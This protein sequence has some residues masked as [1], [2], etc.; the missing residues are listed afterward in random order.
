[1]KKYTA[2]A[3]LLMTVAPTLGYAQMSGD[4]TLSY[5]VADSSD[6]EDSI[7]ATYLGFSTDATLGS[8]V[9]AGLD[10]SFLRASTSVAGAD[11]DLDLVG[12]GVDLAYKLNSGLSFGAYVQRNELDVSVDALGLFGDIAATSTG[13]FVG[14]STDAVDVSAFAGQTKTD[15]EFVDTDITDFGVAVRY[16]P[17]DAS[18]V[19][20]NFIST[21]AESGGVDDTLSSVGLAGGVQLSDQWSLF[22]GLNV[23]DVDDTSLDL[24]NFGVGIGYTMQYAGATM[25][26]EI[27]RATL[28]DGAVDADLDRVQLGVSFPF[29]AKRG[30]SIPKSTVAGGVLT[31]SYSAASEGVR[32]SF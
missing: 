31:N 11:V 7:G 14:Y 24:T 17:S 22:A 10:L 1:M 23:V 3:T 8:N 19:G 16:Q 28:S 5:G 30:T 4:V 20:G 9:L 18:V 6:L 13:L 12:F 26:A 29:G 15:P 25:F 21:R 32:L 2:I 27:A